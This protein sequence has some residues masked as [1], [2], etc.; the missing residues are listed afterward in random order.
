VLWQAADAL[1]E[2]EAIQRLS[3]KGNDI[4]LVAILDH[5]RIAGFCYIDMEICN[6]NL[7][8]YIKGI[9]PRRF[10]GSLNPLFDAFGIEHIGEIATIWDI[11]E[12]ISSGLCFIHSC[13]EVHRDLKPRNST[14]TLS[15]VSDL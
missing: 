11:M 4:N 10:E 9:R 5:G 3:T 14:S 13:R 7:E 15:L 2:I 1:E 12:Q 6:G 8:D